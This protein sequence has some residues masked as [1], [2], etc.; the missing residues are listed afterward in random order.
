MAPLSASWYSVSQAASILSG[1]VIRAASKVSGSVSRSAGAPVGLVWLGHEQQPAAIV[2]PHPLRRQLIQMTVGLQADY[3]LGLGIR[4]FSTIDEL[5]HPRTA[6]AASSGLTSCDAAALV[7]FE[8]VTREVELRNATLSAC[9]ATSAFAMARTAS[10]YG[11]EALEESITRWT[12]V[13]REPR[14]PRLIPE[15]VSA[16]IRSI[17][18]SFVD[19]PMTRDLLDAPGALTN[20]GPVTF[21]AG[22]RGLPIS[23]VELLSHPMPPSKLVELL[24]ARRSVIAAAGSSE[25]VAFGFA[26][27]LISTFGES[28]SSVET[29][30]R[31][32]LFSPNVLA[33]MFVLLARRAP[34]TLHRETWGLFKRVVTEFERTPDWREPTTADLNYDEWE[35]TSGIQTRARLRFR[36][37]VQVELLPFVVTAVREQPDNDSE[38]GMRPSWPQL[39]LW[40]ESEPPTGTSSFDE[41]EYRP[42]HFQGDSRGH[43]RPELIEAER[44]VEFALDRLRALRGRKL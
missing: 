35:L 23:V 5:E 11:I 16:R 34:Q 2:C 29:A 33:W 36:G 9:I 26:H 24:L 8:L 12:S 4:F 37:S 27:L 6:F 17:I 44:A 38:S 40:R 30:R 14:S 25:E 18:R 31:L 15:D 39:S 13:R 28:L 7:V 42:R 1:H 41:R 20:G 22:L 43:T 19:I 10:I 3:P 21:S 32:G